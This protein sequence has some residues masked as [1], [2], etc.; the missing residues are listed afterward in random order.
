MQNLEPM[1][2]TND[3]YVFWEDEADE[4]VQVAPTICRT[5][6]DAT[7]G[8]T[9][10]EALPLGGARG[11]DSPPHLRRWRACKRA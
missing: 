1:A 6:R 5:E 2:R 8:V 7:R 3:N 9:G 4:E 11:G 10:S